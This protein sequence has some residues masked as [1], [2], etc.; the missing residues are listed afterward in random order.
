[1]GEA[2]GSLAGLSEQQEIVVHDISN[3]GVVDA[4]AVEHQQQRVVA[5]GEQLLGVV[6]KHCVATD[7][8]TDGVFKNDMVILTDDDFLMFELAFVAVAWQYCGVIAQLHWLLS[9]IPVAA[10]L[11]ASAIV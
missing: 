2:P 6:Q 8:R 11:V 10:G 3:G 4:D 7:D 9:V 5:V 1:M